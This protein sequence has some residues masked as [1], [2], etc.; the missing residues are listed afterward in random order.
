MNMSGTWLAEVRKLLYVTLFGSIL[1][2]IFGNPFLFIAVGLFALCCAWL[3]QM[4]KI[5]RWLGSPENEPPESRG[6]WGVIYDRIYRLQRESREARNQ[7]Q[8][9]VDYLQ[10][11]FASMREGIVMLDESGAIDWSNASAE[12]LLGL[13]YPADR[14]QPLLNLIRIPDFHKYYL[15]E[16]FS[17]PLQIV[18]P[19][20]Q[21]KVYMI[22][23][24]P[25]GEGDRLVFIRDVTAIARLERMRRDFVGN[26]SHELRTPLTVIMGYIDTLQATAA[27]K[28]ARLVK[29]LS[30]M[31][32]Q[33][34]RMENLLKDLLWLSRIESVGAEKKIDYIDIAGLVQKLTDELLHSQ[35]DR[36]IKL[37]LETD[38]K[39][40]GDYR[41]LD[42]AL[43]NLLS[44]ALKYSDADSPVTITW[45]EK[46]NEFLLTVKDKGIG[47]DS[48][49]LPRLTERFYRVDDSRASKT[50]GTGLGLAIVKHVVAAHDAELRISSRPGKGSKFTI[51]FPGE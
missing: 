20:E 44:N 41:E 49:H 35:P 30:Q 2:W 48:V 9:N 28:E 36:V 33:A 11:S 14:G 27:G 22:E 4:W 18:V 40:L 21:E 43:S 51:A 26:V 25:F 23:V 39:V 46:D 50:G 17:E 31:Q 37:Q 34:K 45:K 7:L 1:G 5:R 42:S 15:E 8:S 10:D 24:T 47:I 16:D 29:P 3:R 38:H 12:R 6:I 19:A 13:K 32:Q